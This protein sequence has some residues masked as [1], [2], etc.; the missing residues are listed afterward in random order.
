MNIINQLEKALKSKDEKELRMR[1]E[2]LVDFLKDEQPK[3]PPQPQMPLRSDSV[4]SQGISNPTANPTSAGAIME[5][6][7][8]IKYR[9]PPNT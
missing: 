3:Y 7:N 9:R 2:V 6:G 1:I 4:A 8:E 5:T